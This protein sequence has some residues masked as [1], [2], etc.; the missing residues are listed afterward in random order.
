MADHKTDH[1]R[2]LG[3]YVLE[4]KD[5]ETDRI[6]GVKD[7]PDDPRIVDYK[8]LYESPKCIEQ[9]EEYSDGDYY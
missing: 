4:S 9:E 7:K 1:Y 2:N 8:V 6:L 3:R 5:P